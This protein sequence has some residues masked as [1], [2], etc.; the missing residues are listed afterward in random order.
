MNIPTRR[1]SAAK[2]RKSEIFRSIR[3]GITRR[4]IPRRS[5]SCDSSRLRINV[6]SYLD[7][8]AARMP[9]KK[10]LTISGV[11]GTTQIFLRL[12]APQACL[13]GGGT[14]ATEPGGPGL[15]VPGIAIH[16]VDIAENDA[17]DFLRHVVRLIVGYRSECSRALSMLGKHH[18]DRPQD[19]L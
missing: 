17:H 11:V 15:S 7:A 13:S 9:R 14:I 19:M 1:A 18:F 5:G 10:K 16:V 3:T 8:R 2:S 4:S 6:R 12:P